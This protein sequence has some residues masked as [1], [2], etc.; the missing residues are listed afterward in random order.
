MSW[1]GIF[2]AFIGKI[3]A[4]LVAAI[5]VEVRKN[6]KVEYIGADDES[7]NAIADSIT[8]ELD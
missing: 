4:Q 1:I 7:E 8:D 6:N 2:A 3:L 5:G